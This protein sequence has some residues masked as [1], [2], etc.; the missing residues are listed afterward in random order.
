MAFSIP[1]GIADEFSAL[2]HAKLDTFKR[3]RSVLVD[4]LENVLR[5]HEVGH[6]PISA[7][8]KGWGRARATAARRYTDCEE[9]SRLWGK[10][11]QR[12]REC[13]CK[14]W[15][16]DK[17]SAKILETGQEVF[18]A[19]H[20]LLGA[21]IALYFPNEVK[22]VKRILVEAGYTVLKPIIKGGMQDLK[23]FRIFVNKR[24]AMI[25]AGSVISED[26]RLQEGKFEK[27]FSGYG[28]SHLIVN[29]PHRLRQRIGL[30]ITEWHGLNA[31]IQIGT[32]VM[33]AWSEVEH[34]VI[35]K[36]LSGMTMT[37]E[38]QRILDLINGIALTGEVALQQLEATTRQLRQSNAMNQLQT[39]QDI[40]LATRVFALDH[41]QLGAWLEEYLAAKNLSTENLPKLSECDGLKELFEV[42]KAHGTHDRNS[43]EKLL[44]SV[45]NLNNIHFLD[46]NLAITA[47]TPPGGGA[48]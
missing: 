15:E 44:G 39:K 4:D 27:A 20:D 17:T 25:S 34:D 24:N 31:E 36:S 38:I 30:P 12:D 32:V 9:M 6:I 8:V 1:A 10:W 42:V 48:T 47:F 5:Y 26:E 40:A 33:H 43:L 21:R 3:C 28:A 29:L 13:Y 18:D 46:I 37:D 19:V 23:R 11:T 41:E 35:Y 16:F 2:Y 14:M 7:R 22:N 45:G